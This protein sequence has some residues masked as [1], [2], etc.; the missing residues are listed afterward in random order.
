MNA[1]QKFLKSLY[2]KGK[3]LVLYVLKFFAS[4]GT[5]QV[6]DLNITIKVI[7]GGKQLPVEAGRI[8]LLR[9]FEKC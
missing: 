8:R 1:G 6:L 4:L 9:K 2:K 7:H 3:C 5:L